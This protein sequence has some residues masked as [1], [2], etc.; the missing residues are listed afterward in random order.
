M[1]SKTIFIENNST[2]TFTV[3]N[4]TFNTPLGFSH[5]ADLVNLNGISNYTGTSFSTVSTMTSATTKSFT[6]DYNYVSTTT[7]IYT[8]S[9]VINCTESFQETVDVELNLASSS[10]VKV[11]VDSYYIHSLLPYGSVMFY[12]GT[13]AN[14][15][16][17]WQLCDGTNSTPNLLNQ[18]VIAAYGDDSAQA[19][20]SITGAYTKIGG[21]KDEIVVTHTHGITE[22]NSGQGHNHTIDFTN[23]I[24]G[25]G[26]QPFFGSGPMT[27]YTEFASTNISIDNE[28]VSGLDQNIPPCYALAYIMKITNSNNINI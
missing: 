25:A 7:G 14:I 11:P 4:I 19:R 27:Y 12:S 1:P 24:D 22:P 20:T 16:A 6:V 28:G 3:T 13:I 9:V 18:F 5:T 23:A 21:N 17:G 2:I 26:G 15:P 10:S 8:A